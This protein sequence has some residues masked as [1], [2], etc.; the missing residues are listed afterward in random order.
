MSA[1]ICEVCEEDYLLPTEP[2]DVFSP[3]T[4]GSCDFFM[5]SMDAEAK[6]DTIED[7]LSA[8]TT[9]RDL[10]ALEN[11]VQHYSGTIL[12]PNHYLL[13]LAKRNFL[14][15]SRKNLIDL[16][17]KCPVEE[18]QELKT[19]FKSKSELFREF[20]WIPEKLNC[21]ETF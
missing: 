8:A 4:C 18:Q 11:F 1:L 9:K 10:K 2:L 21:A 3:W 14:Y 13:L 6:V 20:N 17:T 12:H 15:I 19:A 5:N 16:L 7:E